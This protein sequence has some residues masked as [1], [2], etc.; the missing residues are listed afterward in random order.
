MKAIVQAETV[1][2]HLKNGESITL[3]G[4]PKG[5][6]FRITEDNIIGYKPYKVNDS[7]FN[8]TF[9]GVVGTDSSVAFTNIVNPTNTSI[10]VN[11]TLDNKD[12]TGDLFDFT[13]TGTRAQCRPIT[14]TPTMRVRR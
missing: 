7:D 8:G 14:L 13:L 3:T 4:L 12:Y 6:S 2:S 10:T 9:T 1:R 11:K 5:A